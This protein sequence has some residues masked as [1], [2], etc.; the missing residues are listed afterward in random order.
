MNEPTST[1]LDHASA[2]A[3]QV[4]SGRFANQTA[5]RVAG[6]PKYPR[7]PATS[8]WS[9]DPTG[10]EP[11]LNLDVNAVPDLGFHAAPSTNSSEADVPPVFASPLA[12]E[13]EASPIFLKRRV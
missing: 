4:S 10:V 12:V 6:V 8:H 13:T 3:D 11:P 1:Y 5:T 2:E 9:R 7:Q